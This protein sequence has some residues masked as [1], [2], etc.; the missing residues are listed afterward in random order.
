MN[1]LAKEY[2]VRATWSVRVARAGVS[3]AALGVLAAGLGSCSLVSIKTPEKPL[4]TQELNAR[5]LTHEYSAHFITSVAQT[6][7]QIYAAS[8]DK[9]VRL[10]ALRWKIA[11]AGASQHAAS[12]MAPM[13]SL[14]DTWALAVQMR[15]FLALGAGQTLFGAQQQVAVALAVNLAQEA[16][17]MAHKLSTPQE[18]AIQQ[19][20]IDDYSSAHPITGL[21]F[22][23]AS[24]VGVWAQQGGTE[25]KLIDTL[26]TLPEAMAQT[27]DLVRMYGDTVPSQM[28]WKAQLAAQESGLSSEELQT[29]LN[30]LNARIAKLSEMANAAPGRFSDIARETRERFDASWMELVHAI[31]NSGEMFASSADTERQALVKAV[32]E[33]RTAATADAQRLA[34]QLLKDAGEQARRL[35]LEAVALVV[36]AALILLGLPFAAGYYVGRARAQ[37]RSTNT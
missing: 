29:A 22:A 32:D 35:L 21:D 11:A 30:E 25:V 15:D 37:R 19:R 18:F 34:T 36:L 7:D 2:P 3:F 31:N 28:M 14:L 24:V 12:Q 4:S 13:L 1:G 9:D 6:A 26:G 20:F 23:R 5:V 17:D 16:T 33:E 27:G 10:N 8:D